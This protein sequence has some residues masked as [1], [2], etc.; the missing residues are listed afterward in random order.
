MNRIGGMAEARS[1][2]MRRGRGASRMDR[3]GIGPVTT[4][5][6]GNATQEEHMVSTAMTAT[7]TGGATWTWR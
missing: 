3:A 4:A 6:R 1:G 5:R 7:M 2:V